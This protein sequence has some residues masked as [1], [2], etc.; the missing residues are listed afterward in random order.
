M[1]T[2]ACTRRGSGEPLVLLHALGSSRRSWDAVLP[3]LAEHFDVIAV[4]LPGFGE[5]PPLR[6]GIEPHP[7]NLARGVAELLEEQGVTV[8]HVVGNSL[9]GWIA[10]ELAGLAPVRSVTLLS[11]AGLWTRTP[12]YCRVSLELTRWAA[13]HAS[14][15]LSW[16]VRSRVGRWLVF[17]QTHGRPARLSVPEAVDAIRSLGTSVGFKEA[18]AATLHRGY[19][20]GP[21]I[22][23]PVTVAF[24]SR[25]LLLPRRSARRLGE[26][27][28]DHRVVSLPGC[29]HLPMTDDPEAVVR[30]IVESAARHRIA[31]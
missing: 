25:D 5:S 10:L 19:L 26:L 14:R 20:A 27:P 4:D 30:V 12:L 24:G 6:S 16:L 17:R 21:P 28:P 9:G 29:G 18:F 13:E 15:P 22:N 11:P 3:A 2:L 1:T 23:A 31:A 7:Q 8:P